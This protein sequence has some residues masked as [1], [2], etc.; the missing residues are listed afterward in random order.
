MLQPAHAATQCT[1][2]LNSLN[3]HKGHIKQKN[4]TQKNN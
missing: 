1:G 3:F 2:P 4:K